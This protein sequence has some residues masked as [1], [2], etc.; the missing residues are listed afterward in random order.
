MCVHV[1][2]APILSVFFSSEFTREGRC[3]PLSV[4]F[5]PISCWIWGAP[6]SLYWTVLWVYVF[7]ASLSGGCFSPAFWG[8]PA[9][10][11][12]AGRLCF[13]ACWWGLYSF[14]CQL[15]VLRVIKFVF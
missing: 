3:L 5:S 6:N 8:G 2:E 4:G 15:V 12:C 11:V 1:W 14:A 13:V 10:G 7:V 9:L